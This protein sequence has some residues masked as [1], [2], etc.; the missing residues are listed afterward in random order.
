MAAASTGAACSIY[1]SPRAVW[2]EHRAT[3]R[4]RDLDITGLDYAQLEKAPALWPWPEGATEG[5]QRLYD[6]GVFATAD[7][8]ARFVDAPYM[9][10]AEE[11]DARFPFAL[12]TGSACATSGTA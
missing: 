4:G 8:R 12:N 6:D 3:T 7:G 10:P 9:K 1:A 2:N 5:R 11:R